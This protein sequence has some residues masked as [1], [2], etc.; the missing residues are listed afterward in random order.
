MVELEL[1]AIC[2]AA[3]K[4][5]NFIDG[6]PL[7]LFEIWTDHAPLI[8]ILNKYTLPEIENKRLQ[9][10]RA[11]LDHLQFHAV[12]IKGSDNTEADVLS[13][14]PHRKA[15]KEDI[16]EDETTVSVAMI[17][18]ID[19]F[20]KSN[21]DYASTP[22]RDERLLELRAHQDHEYNALKTA[23]IKDGWPERKIDLAQN[24]EPFWSQ[25][26][27]LS[28][29]EDG[30]IVKDGRLFVPAGLRQTYLQRLL[31][32]HQQ[33]DKMEARA[34]KSI[35]W[36]FLSR[37]IKNIAKT[38]RPCQEKLP[39]QAAEPE[40]AHE[41]ALYPFQSLHMDLATYEGRQFLILIDQFSSFPHVYECGKHATTKQVTDHITSFI[42]NYSAPV[43]IYS[44]GGPQFK[45]EFDDFCKRWSIKHVKSSPHYPQSNGV[46]E[47]AVKEMK[48]IIRATFNNQTR[49][50]D[51]SGFAAAMLMFRNTP[52][53]PT[54]LSP[55]Q[56]VFGR[57]LQDTLPFSRQMLRPQC[58]FEIEKRRLEV[59]EGQRRENDASKR[60]KL[61]LLR[62]AQRIRFQD[63]VTKKWTL[64]GKVIGFGVTDR[65]YWVQ[66]DHTARRYRRNRRF[67]R[68]IEI[69]ATSPP[70]QPVQAPVAKNDQ[71]SFVRGTK[72][73]GPTPSVHEDSITSQ[74]KSIL[75]GPQR[76][77]GERVRT[78]VVRFEAG[79]EKNKT[80]KVG[81]PRKTFP[82]E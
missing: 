4:C 12:W 9:R 80:G 1:L 17:A 38:C 20:E 69:E 63:P 29:D 77:I 6:L 19:L 40:R 22:L 73:P 50:L 47:S 75:S 39:S 34:R 21:V 23:I 62:P 71:K 52:R 27:S 24:L 7:K 44:D 28:I 56:L 25:R 13:R 2:W 61:P 37:D 45:D 59:R 30:F 64:T 76:R 31:A 8:P 55:A 67:I 46:A 51:K 43:T 57:H 18:T 32:M 49:M 42:S 78:K 65:D 15:G 16:I 10:L 35:W 11:K 74:P 60:R 68:P 14:I 70:S 81:R 54:D 26:Y 79:E 3:K 82:K 33:A 48:K 36:P 41:E 66:E 72:P 58:R 5:A 53:S